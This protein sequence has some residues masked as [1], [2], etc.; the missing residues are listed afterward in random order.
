MDEDENE[1]DADLDNNAVGCMACR[2]VEQFSTSATMFASGWRMTKHIA[3]TW[4]CPKDATD[5]KW[6]RVVAPI[7]YWGASSIIPNRRLS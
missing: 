1:A 6:A 4:L 2:T 5:P 7:Y 3:P